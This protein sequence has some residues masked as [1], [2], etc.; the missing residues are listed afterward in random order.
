MLSA[1]LSDHFRTTSGALLASVILAVVVF[2]AVVLVVED[3]IL[4]PS[5]I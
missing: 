5:F 4:L 3:E 2:V 1:T